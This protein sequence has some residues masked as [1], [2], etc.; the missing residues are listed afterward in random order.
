VL[1]GGDDQDTLSGGVGDDDLDPGSHFNGIDD[2][3]DG[4]DTVDGG[5][6]SDTVEY[7]SRN[8]PVVA[9]LSGGSTATTNNGEAGEHDSLVN[10]E[11]ITGGDAGDTLIGNGADNVI[12]DGG[13]A[14]DNVSGLGGNDTIDTQ[15]D[16]VDTAACGDGADTLWADSVADG[17]DVNDA[18]AADCEIVNGTNTGGGTGGGGTGGGGTGGG[19]T[20][21]TGGTTGGGTTG[22]GTTGGGTGT[23]GGIDN[24]PPPQPTYTFGAFIASIQSSP[25]ANKVYGSV[26]IAKDGAKLEVDVYYGKPSKKTLVGKATKKGLKTGNVPFQVSL[27]KKASKAAAKTKKGVKMT[28]KVT[29]TP[30]SGKAFVKTFKVTVKKGKAHAC[31]RVARVRAH[32]AC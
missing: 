19:G 6:G 22:G 7:L 21:G 18:V 14:G 25:K 5:A 1:S 12:N 9:D 10:L 2:V 8:H 30:A 31:F 27:N 4:S 23:G 28:V 24:P 32:A 13:G 3:G 29:I 16:A 17:W 20:G 15:D 11:N 26:T